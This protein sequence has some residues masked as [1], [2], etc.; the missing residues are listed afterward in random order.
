MLVSYFLTGG[1]AMTKVVVDAGTRRKLRNL[2]ED[3]QFTDEDGKI[4]GS[5]TPA[6]KNSR[7]EPQIGEEEIQRRLREGGGRSL[8]EI[9]S[10]LEKRS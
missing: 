4:L 3:M 9:M 5:F 10:D 8:T 6:A 2:A 7:R 1:F